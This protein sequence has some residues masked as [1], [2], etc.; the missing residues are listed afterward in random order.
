[1]IPKWLIRQIS[2]KHG[3]RL[4]KKV[5][6]VEE[7]KVLDPQD[8]RLNHCDICFKEVESYPIY[9]DGKVWHRE[10]DPMRVK[11]PPVAFPGAVIGSARSAWSE[12]TK[13]EGNLPDGEYR[14]WYG[15]RT[16]SSEMRTCRAC[17][18]T[19]WRH[20][21]AVAHKDDSASWV[22]GQKCTERLVD[23]YKRLLKTH[24]CVICRAQTYYEKWGVPLCQ[25]NTVN[26]K[27]I[28]TWKFVNDGCFSLQIELLQDDEEEKELPKPWESAT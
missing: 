2:L 20:D 22:G 9:R 15:A 13:Q 10:C 6:F 23:A 18:K 27:C 17:G 14:F 16:P 8:W 12:E 25:P 1:M 7:R 11:Q 19:L 24:K 26:H 3:R 28:E 21:Q 5:L 4:P